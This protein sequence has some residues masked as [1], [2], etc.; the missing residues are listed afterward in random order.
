MIDSCFSDEGADDF[1][2]SPAP[3]RNTGSASALKTKRISS[4]VLADDDFE[5]V[6]PA[7]GT[8]SLP[9]RGHVSTTEEGTEADDDDGGFG[10]FSAST[11]QN[12]FGG[13][14][15]KEEVK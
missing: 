8:K 14:K 10:A 6:F 9:P 2:M 11:K 4:S 13:K 15:R 1:A 12:V 5:V 3:E 7:P